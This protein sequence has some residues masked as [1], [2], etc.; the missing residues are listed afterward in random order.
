[1]EENSVEAECIEKLCNLF[2]FTSP[3]V[4]KIQFLALY[5]Q[6]EEVLLFILHTLT[7]LCFEHFP[8]YMQNHFWNQI[9]M[10]WWPITEKRSLRRNM[11]RNLGTKALI[12]K[13]DFLTQT[14]KIISNHLIDFRQILIDFSDEF[15]L[16]IN[17]HKAQVKLI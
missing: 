4:L 8:N 17:I 2:I 7:F 14:S 9:L 12:R 3:S 15:I 5:G 11:V 6:R 10:L 16:I 13:T 1:M